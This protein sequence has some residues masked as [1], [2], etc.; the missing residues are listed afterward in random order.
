MK[1]TKRSLIEIIVIALMTT[2]ICAIT[3]SIYGTAYA[4]LD[5][6]RCKEVPSQTV[7]HSNCTGA[8]T[9]QCG[10]GVCKQVE[11]APFS[12]CQI[13]DNCYTCS[14]TRTTGTQWVTL[15]SCMPN[16]Q[17]TICSCRE[18]FR[19]EPKIIVVTSCTDQQ[20]GSC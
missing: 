11:T 2:T 3:F 19:P 13:E 17:G 16:A 8:T 4:Q 18:W 1:N 9:E 7:N 6:Y 5:G 10:L 15:G 14:T 12:I 20:K